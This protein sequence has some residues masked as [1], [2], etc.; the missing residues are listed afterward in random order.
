MQKIGLEN[1]QLAMFILNL[2]SEHIKF[3]V[4]SE[5]FQI[6]IRKI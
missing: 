6:L 5:T 1:L 3:L 2:T 4:V